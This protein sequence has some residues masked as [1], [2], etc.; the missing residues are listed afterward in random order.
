[1]H[2]VSIRAH[3]HLPADPAWDAWGRSGASHVP[4]LQCD[5]RALELCNVF[6]RRYEHG[7]GCAGSFARIEADASAQR[8][9]HLLHQRESEAGSR[10]LAPAD[11][12]H[13]LERLEHFLVEIGRDAR[14]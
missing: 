14:T 4:P 6:C 2:S 9:N 1:M 3:R 11:V 13:L 12:A 7:E 10:A 5:T 8:M